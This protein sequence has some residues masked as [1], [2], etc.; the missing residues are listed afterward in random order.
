[1][2]N[3]VFEYFG[4]PLWDAELNEGQ[5]VELRHWD[6]TDPAEGVSTETFEYQVD[7]GDG[8]K[9][10]R[11]SVV[12]I[13]NPEL[14]NYVVSPPEHDE[15]MNTYTGGIPPL[16]SQ[17]VSTF[18]GGAVRWQQMIPA[19]D[20]GSSARSITGLSMKSWEAATSPWTASYTNFKIYVNH[21]SGTSLSTTYASNYGTDRTLVLSKASYTISHDGTWGWI[22]EVK[23]DT[24]FSYDGSSN[25]V[26]EIQYTGGS[27]TQFYA[28]VMQIGYFSNLPTW[29]AD[30]INSYSNPTTTTTGSKY[31]WA[32]F[33]KFHFK[34][35][36][37]PAGD[38]PYKHLYRDDPFVG[39]FYTPTIHV[40]DDDTGEGTYEL[41]FKVN[42]IKPVID[43]ADRTLGM[44][45]GKESTGASL[46]L[47]SAD[48]FDPGTQYDISDPNEVW[49]YWWDLD[50]NGLM[51]NAPDVVGTVPQ[52]MVDQSQD[53]SDGTVPSVTAA[54]PDD[55]IN[56]PLALYLFDDDITHSLSSSPTSATGTMT[57]HN[58]APVASIEVFVPM[59]VRLRMSGRK[60]NDVKVEIIQTDARG[61]T[62]VYDAMSIE[63]MPG[64]PKENPFSDGTPSA[65]LFVKAD[66]ANTINLVVTFDAN[67][68]PNDVSNPDDPTGSD[69]TWV[70]L[71]F[72]LEEDYDP[73]EDDQSSSGHH[74]AQSFKFN[75][76]TGGIQRETVDV[77]SA[78]DNRWAWL[79]GH[80][81]DDASDDAAFYWTD[82]SGSSPLEHSGN[83]VYYNDGTNSLF[84]TPPGPTYKDGYPTPWTGTAPCHYEDMH[85][86]KFTTGFSVSLYTVD[87]D[88]G[89]DGISGK[90][91][92]ATYSVA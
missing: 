1:L 28:G 83:I 40:W 47:P 70:Y 87:D 33:V 72:P 32:P 92:V 63:R 90:S 86:F 34:P 5:E 31:G 30:A 82:N 42:N 54:V 45:M 61:Q 68:D 80:S 2:T 76:Q 4:V 75:A 88:D 22:P 85:L 19:D 56:R 84:T 27:G 73:R 14:P 57:V 10:E 78:L 9:G 71:D 66:P 58:V 62:V 7:W 69:P 55:Y 16:A 59:E 23:F 39:D 17:Y 8:Q 81:Q 24:A 51:N 60:E 50:G 46:I 53:T 13:I 49:T 18:L 38:Q 77:T 41:L 35:I 79:I 11:T 74:W 65:P 6:I 15:N 3:E 20:M 12:D 29:G 43:L 21:F 67:P 52:S 37:T 64:Q 26:F 36:A 25:V 89:R 44:V 91:N 48:F